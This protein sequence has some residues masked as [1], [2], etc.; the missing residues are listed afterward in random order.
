V[1]LRALL[2]GAACLALVVAGTRLRW[3]AP[4]VL[5]A[6]FGAVLVLRHV[7]PLAD[8]VPRWALIGTAGALL[9]AMGITWEQRL[10]DARSVA[11]YVRALR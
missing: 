10:R 3:G 9:V 5:G 1:S 6:V 11:G 8:A 2:L 4:L 7:T